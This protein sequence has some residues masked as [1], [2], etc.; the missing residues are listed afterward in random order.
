MT[1]CPHKAPNI[2]PA[3]EPPKPKATPKPKT[4]GKPA[5]Q[6]ADEGTEN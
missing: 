2:V 4:K 5:V 1:L 3:Q 6:N